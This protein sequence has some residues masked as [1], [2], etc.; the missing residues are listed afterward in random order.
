MDT[1]VSSNVFLLLYYELHLSIKSWALVPGLIIYI[2]L[3]N[4][5]FVFGLHMIT[6]VECMNDEE[7]HLEVD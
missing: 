7:P 5:Y 6:S 4:S 1:W 2:S 3:P